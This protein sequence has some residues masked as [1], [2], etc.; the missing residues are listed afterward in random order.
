M[1]LLDR[2]DADLGLSAGRV[3]YRFATPVEDFDLRI[4]EGLIEGVIV[5]FESRIELVDGVFEEFASTAFDA[6]LARSTSPHWLT[7]NP[8]HEREA[9]SQWGHAV[10]LDRRSDGLTGTFRLRESMRGE[11]A[12]LLTTSHRWLSAGFTSRRPREIPVTEGVVIR[13]V[14]ATLVHVAATPTPAYPEARILA[15]RSELAEPS[16]LDRRPAL[17]ETYRLLDELTPSPQSEPEE[18]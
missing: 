10:A 11:W 2:L 1:T 3:Q 6:S 18:S 17:D 15:M 14:A 5:P 16:T 7:L 9:R 4:V 8:N 13:H 12:E